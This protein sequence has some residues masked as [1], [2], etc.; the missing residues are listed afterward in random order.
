MA[1]YFNPSWTGDY[2]NKWH[3]CSCSQPTSTK[4][5]VKFTSDSEPNAS[6]LHIIKKNVSSVLQT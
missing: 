6:E 2:Y 3:E 1:A 5:T 4:K